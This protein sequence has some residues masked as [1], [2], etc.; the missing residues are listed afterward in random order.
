MDDQDWHKMGWNNLPADVLDRVVSLMGAECMHT[1]GN[2][3]L[4]C[5][6]WKDNINS[7][8]SHLRIFRRPS[9]PPTNL[10]RT[11]HNL[12]KVIII[13]SQDLDDQQE[14]E[15]WGDIRRLPYLQELNIVRCRGKLRFGA[16]YLCEMYK[17]ETLWID[18]QTLYHLAEKGSSLANVSTLVLGQGSHLGSQ[19]LK[20]LHRCEA[21][22]R[23]VIL[24][25]GELG[26][27]QVEKIGKIAHIREL[28][29]VGASSD[30]DISH[31][32]NVKKLI[33]QRGSLN[34]H[35][36]EDVSALS[37][38]ESLSLSGCKVVHNG[39][40]EQLNHLHGLE[41]LRLCGSS[42]VGMEVNVEQPGSVDSPST[43][44]LFQCPG[45][46][47]DALRASLRSDTNLRLIQKPG[48]VQLLCRF[49]ESWYD[50]GL[51]IFVLMQPLAH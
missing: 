10:W 34:D 6:S 3:R 15:I 7:R 48:E 16:E 1:I 18:G 45:V 36:F 13:C 22:H 28:A 44:E 47:E 17:L 21:L 12:Q 27:E 20:F 50:T 38:L 40:W 46:D 31:L 30:L 51:S 29:L 8:I 23:L 5:L 42:E 49:V 4:V 26:K 35:I 41:H 24:D 33:I 43:I 39:D 14:S 9:S 25:A 32:T 37:S 2:L 11:F 19:V